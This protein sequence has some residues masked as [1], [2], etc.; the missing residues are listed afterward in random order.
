MNKILKILLIPI[1]IISVTIISN[2]TLF[3]KSNSN[4]KSISGGYIPSR[5]AVTPYTSLA[6]LGYF[7]T[8]YTCEV[9]LLDSSKHLEADDHSTSSY[10][11]GARFEI[12]F[13]KNFIFTPEIEFQQNKIKSYSYNDEE[14]IYS[15]L[16]ELNVGYTA[17]YINIPLMINFY[18]SPNNGGSGFIGVG[19]KI[20][21]NIT[22]EKDQIFP[23]NP[24]FISGAVTIGVNAG[25]ET[26]GFIMGIV[27]ERTITNIYKDEDFLINNTKI[28]SIFGKNLRIGAMFGFKIPIIK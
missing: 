10:T 12:C 20:H 27:A 23:V 15:K 18:L 22:K 9:N 7:T 16:P 17:R 21:Y 14:I 25:D 24:Y 8:E 1:I 6:C 11:I 28:S 4:K 19:P 13:F 2:I 3:A 26:G 5:F